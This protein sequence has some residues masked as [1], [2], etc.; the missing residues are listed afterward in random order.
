VLERE[1]R[2]W[3]HKLLDDL[4]VKTRHDSTTLSNT[5]PM[6]DMRMQEKARMEVG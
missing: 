3:N 4:H 6:K 1:R 5:E 2:D